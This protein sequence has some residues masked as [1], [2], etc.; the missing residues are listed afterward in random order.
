MLA[1][2]AF[3]AAQPPL[4]QAWVGR[5][6]LVLGLVVVPGWVGSRSS[7]KHPAHP[8]EATTIA[9]HRI[10]MNIRGVPWLWTAS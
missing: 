1:I 10:P 5:G 9:T 8:L 2:T 3:G 4:E 7:P 6:S